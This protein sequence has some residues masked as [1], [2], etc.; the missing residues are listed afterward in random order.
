MF[1]EINV[2][3]I[4]IS[5][6]MIFISNFVHIFTRQIYRK[7]LNVKLLAKNFFNLKNSEYE[8]LKSVLTTARYYL[9]RQ[10]GEDLSIESFIQNF[11]NSR[12]PEFK[13]SSLRGAF[14]YTVKMSFTLSS[15][16]SSIFL[17]YLSVSS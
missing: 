7:T 17:T 9:H 2:N 1:N 15:Q 13:K 4:S 5:F 10:F 11:H 14:T 3:N 16:S 6:F 12:I 8:N